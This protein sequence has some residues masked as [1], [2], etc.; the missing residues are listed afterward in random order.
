MMNV[1]NIDQGPGSVRT[2]ARATDGGAPAPPEQAVAPPRPAPQP[3]ISLTRLAWFDV[4]GDG[5]IDPR[6]AGSGG[7]ATLLVPAHEVDL[8][9]YGRV[10]GPPAGTRPAH[11]TPTTDEHQQP[12]IGANP[13][14]A[15][16]AAEAYQR[17]GQAPDAS[18]TPPPSASPDLTLSTAA[19]E[20]AA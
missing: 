8:P 7:D 6:S 9:T 20:R 17:Y 12:T 2:L 1:P 3:G 4:N 15:N 10:S 16:R 19:P 18:P 14:Q 13:A 11:P 5:R